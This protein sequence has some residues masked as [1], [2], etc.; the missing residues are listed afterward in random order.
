[1]GNCNTNRRAFIFFIGFWS[2]LLCPVDEGGRCNDQ[3]LSLLSAEKF[4]QLNAAIEDK[5]AS[6]FGSGVAQVPTQSDVN[7]YHATW[8]P[9]RENLGLNA[10]YVSGLS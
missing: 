10:P 2:T 6:F 5:Q 8:V 9:T 4:P 7:S 1:M 3:L